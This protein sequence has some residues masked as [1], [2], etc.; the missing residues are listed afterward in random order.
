MKLWIVRILL[1]V[2]IC[3]ILASPLE[4]FPGGINSVSELLQIVFWGMITLFLLRL[5]R[6]P[7]CGKKLHPFF[8]NHCPY[9]K[10]SI[11]KKPRVND[12]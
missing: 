2:A 5:M 6:C 1:F 9:C 7:H 8:L 10:E 3:G 11:F 12:K 4:S